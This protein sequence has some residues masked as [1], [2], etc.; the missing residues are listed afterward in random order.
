MGDFLH[1]AGNNASILASITKKRGPAKKC[2]FEIG[3]VLND[4]RLQSIGG[5]V[6]GLTIWNMAIVPYLLYNS[7]SW[8]D[9]G[10][11]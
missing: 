2:I 8:A 4:I 11:E 1:Q 9:M 3:A 6:S 10:E 7:D 5:I